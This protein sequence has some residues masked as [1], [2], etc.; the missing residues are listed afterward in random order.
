M[1]YR[2]NTPRVTHDTIEGETIILD[3]QSGAYFSTDKIG[4]EVWRLLG[5]GASADQIAGAIQGRYGAEKTI[6]DEA[7]GVFLA[8][9][10]REGLIVPD[11]SP[12][13][14]SLQ[15]EAPRPEYPAAFVSPT[16]RKYTDMQK[17]LLLDPVH[18]VGEGGWPEPQ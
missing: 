9:L 12:A 11:S 14:D 5:Q 3:F 1:K 8:E 16:L 6:I 2:I 15:P 7:V 10:A 18:E 4:T 13:P 17:I